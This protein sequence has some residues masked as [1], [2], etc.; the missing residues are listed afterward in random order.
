MADPDRA[1]AHRRRDVGA[2]EAGHGFGLLFALK[3]KVRLPENNTLPW[4][5]LGEEARLSSPPLPPV[6]TSARR[7][8]TRCFTT[9]PKGL[10]SARSSL[11]KLWPR[12]KPTMFTTLIP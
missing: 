2:V 5:R 9:F 10:A 12:L 7:S 6:A 1:A 11:R 3:L 8:R 4:K